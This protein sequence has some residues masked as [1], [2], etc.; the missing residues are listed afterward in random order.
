MENALLEFGRKLQA[1]PGAIAFVYYAGHGVQARR[2]PEA[3][4]ENFLIPVRSGLEDEF[5]AT[6]KALPVR[7]ILE[8]LAAVGVRAGIIVLD[9]C[10]DNGL[11]R[12]TMAANTR[13]LS[14][15]VSE[16]SS[17]LIA[18]STEPGRVALDSLPGSTVLLSPYARRLAEQ[19]VVPGKS[20]TDVFVDVGA[21][22]AED[23]HNQQNPE[24][25]IRLSARSARLYF[26]RPV[27]AAPKVTRH[28]VGETFRD[29]PDCPELVMIPP[30]R[31]RMGS[32]ADE[33][34]RYDNEGPPHT[35]T[36]SYP[37]AVSRYPVT[38]EQWRAFLRASSHEMSHAHCYTRDRSN[39]KWIQAGRSWQ[40]TGFAQ[41]DS[42]PVVCVPWAD[43]YAYVEWLSGK[44]GKHYRML[45]EAEYE[46]ANRAGSEDAYSWGADIRQACAYT[47]GSDQSRLQLGDNNLSPGNILQCNDGYPRT[48]PVGHFKP[49]R[50]GLYDM[51]GNVAS[52]TADCYNDNYFG[53]PTDGSAWRSGDCGQRVVRG[54][55]WHNLPRETRTAARFKGDVGIS[56]YNQG[57]RLARSAD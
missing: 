54:S 23:T 20:I 39:S 33:N 31:F 28:A 49:N 2:R 32:P 17:F 11:R 15:T 35:V 21:Q 42:H 57:L 53:A 47:N 45:T 19:I 4:P 8:Q 52:W 25:T 13:G 18:Y 24:A 48:S 5:Q 9:A 56:T 7:E 41:G 43:A 44:T 46:Y 55:S 6:S 27:P 1:N 12:S 30:G 14:L 51:S 38:L 16:A 29:C 22:V 3:A 36:I 10:R 26:A 37:L 40:D 34:G 50:F